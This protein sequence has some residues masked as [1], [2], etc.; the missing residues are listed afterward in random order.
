MVRICRVL[1]AIEVEMDGEGAQW[2][3]NS[4]SRSLRQIQSG[5]RVSSCASP[6]AVEPKSFINMSKRYEV[7]EAPKAF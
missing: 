1:W 2:D 5:V 6:R 4:L 7:R 3:W